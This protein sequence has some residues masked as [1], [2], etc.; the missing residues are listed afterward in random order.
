M[1]DLVKR[2]FPMSYADLIGLCNKIHDFQVRDTNEFESFGILPSAATAFKTKINEF[3]NLP[4]DLEFEADLVNATMAKSSIANDIRILLRALSTRAKLALGRNNG[5]IRR[6][7]SKELSSMNDNDLSMFA[8]VAAKAAEEFFDLLS[9]FGLT[10]AM[11]DE[12][13]GKVTA[14]DTAVSL[15]VKAIADRDNATTIRVKKANEL[16]HLLIKYSQIGKTM[17]YETNEAYYNDYVIYD[18]SGGSSSGGGNGSGAVPGVPAERSYDNV[19]HVFTWSAVAEATGYEVEC[20]Y[21]DAEENWVNFYNGPETHATV[22]PGDGAWYI[23]VRAKNIYGS[24]EWSP[25]MFI[26]YMN[27]APL[28]LVPTVTYGANTQVSLSF[29]KMNGVPQ[30]RL[31]L[32]YGPLGSSTV[33]ELT[34]SIFVTDTPVAVPTTVANMRYF[35]GLKCYNG[36]AYGIISQIVSVDVNGL[37]P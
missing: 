15:Q 7:H 29:S 16:Y 35:M 32:G 27:T 24:G 37:T 5:E 28:N 26:G 2:A 8:K 3:V 33:P 9:P 1:A 17:W 4:Q 10:Q 23:R 20:M 30:Y 34:G 18:Y 14:F 11:I 19:S 12:L 21:D 22:D 31:Y 6:F 25:T 13:T 36:Y